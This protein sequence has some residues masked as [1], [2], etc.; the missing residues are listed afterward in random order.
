MRKKVPTMAPPARTG[1]PELSRLRV[2]LLAVGIVLLA[3]NLRPALTSVAPLI[4]QIRTDTGMSN[5]VAGLLTTLPLLA[6]GLLSPGAPLLARRFGVLRDATRGWTV[7]LVLLLA[8]TVCL[9]A[10][11]LGAGRDA[12]VAA[13]SPGDTE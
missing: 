11:G 8:I 1:N 13:P 2:V 10:A 5:G 12:H 3:A 7:P 6:F 4:G 9:L